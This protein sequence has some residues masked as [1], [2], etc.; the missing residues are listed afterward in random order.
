MLH[1]DA[2]N[3]APEL[4]VKRDVEGLGCAF[5]TDP[6]WEPAVIHKLVDCHPDAKAQQKLLNVTG[7]LNR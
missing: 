6:A 1:L 7:Q 2:I 4:V 3:R 5:A